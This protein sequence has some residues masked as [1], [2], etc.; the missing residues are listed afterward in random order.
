MSVPVDNVRP[1]EDNICGNM[2]SSQTRNEEKNSE[3]LCKRNA[4][5]RKLKEPQGRSWS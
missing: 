1:S 2:M 4:C 3:Q 5:S